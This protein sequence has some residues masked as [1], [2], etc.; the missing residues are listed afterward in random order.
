MSGG[1]LN[2]ACYFGRFAARVVRVIF[3]QTVCLP[4]RHSGPEEHFPHYLGGNAYKLNSAAENCGKLFGHLPVRERLRA[5]KVIRFALVTFF[6]QRSS[7]GRPDIRTSIALI[8]ASPMAAKNFPWAMI[9]SRKPS[10]PCINRFGR[11][12]V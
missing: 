5:S 3:Y 4:N 2:S 6:R 12:K 10:K 8:L 7:P 9:V 1:V 11:R